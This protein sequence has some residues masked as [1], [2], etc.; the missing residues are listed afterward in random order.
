MR[1]PLFRR[2]FP[3]AALAALMACD[4]AAVPCVATAQGTRIP[5]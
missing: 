3:S 4:H 2:I 1:E 5:E